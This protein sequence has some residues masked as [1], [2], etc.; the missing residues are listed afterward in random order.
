MKAENFTKPKCQKCGMEGVLYQ[1]GLC[2]TCLSIE[3]NQVR[4]VIDYYRNAA[5]FREIKP[6]LLLEKRA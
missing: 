4:P 3:L 2:R 5:N 6:G 1:R